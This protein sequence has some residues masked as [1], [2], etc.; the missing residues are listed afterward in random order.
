MKTGTHVV[1]S[2]PVYVEGVFICLKNVQA[3]LFHTHFSVNTNKEMSFFIFTAFHFWGCV[4]C[5][6]FVVANLY[7]FS[8]WNTKDDVRQKVKDRQPPSLFNFIA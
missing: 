8:F 6:S 5:Y 7:D 2:L 1:Y 4:V 3:V